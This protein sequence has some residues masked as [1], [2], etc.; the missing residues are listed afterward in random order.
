MNPASSPQKLEVLYFTPYFGLTLMDAIGF[1]PG[2]AEDLCTVT[3]DHSRMA[4]ADAVLFHIPNMK[5]PPRIPK[6]PGQLWVGM[7]MES[8]AN[9]PL[10]AE[11][12]FM[13]HFDITMNFRRGSD[14]P[15][16]YFDPRHLADLKAP[17]RWKF[18]RAP[19]VYIASNEGAHNNRHEFV[20]ELMQCMK[21]DSY[22][23]SRNNRRIKHDVGRDTKLAIISRYLFNFAFENS[24]SI[25]YVTEK[26]FDP[27]IAGTVPVYM[28]AS[29][30][31]A[32]LPARKCIIKAG[33][34]AGPRELAQYLLML[35]KD[36]AEYR[37]YLAWKNEP[38]Q[39]SFLDLV[40][41][42]ETPP[43]R[44]LCYKIMER[45]KAKP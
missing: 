16:L 1:S 25:D 15:M 33:D 38:L 41:L 17:P 6:R 32:Y 36:R 13:R 37:S 40:R 29:N 2:V 8:D 18:R 9:Y 42:D 19:A 39:K 23:K 35:K 30:I 28:G 22:G 31:D 27:L 5:E 45:R 43:L 44:R 3:T 10:Q 34:F 26:L 21:V 24:N 12:S 4:I 14:I 20:G 7:S 11:P